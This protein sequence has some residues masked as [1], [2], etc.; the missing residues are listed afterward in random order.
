MTV[1]MV[2]IM[3]VF[4]RV[5][6]S[7]VRVLVGVRLIAARVGM[8]MMRIIMLMLMRMCD[9]FVRVFMRM[10]FHLV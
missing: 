1:W 9:L 4:V 3:P 6:C 2:L 7:R 8:L 10:V 5:C